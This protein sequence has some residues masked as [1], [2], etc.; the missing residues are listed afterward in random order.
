[1]TNIQIDAGTLMADLDDGIIS[2]QV[3]KY[4]EEGNTNLGKVKVRPGALRLPKDIKNFFTVDLGHDRMKPLGGATI[5]QDSAGGLFAA[6]D[7]SSTDEGKSLLARYKANDPAAP[8]RLSIEVDDVVITNGEITSGAIHGAAIVER[9]AFPSSSLFAQD[10]GPDDEDK[11]EVTDENGVVWVKKT[12]EIPAPATPAEGTT[13]TTAP[14]VT[15][16]KEEP[17]GAPVIPTTL[18]ASAANLVTPEGTVDEKSAREVFTLM[19]NAMKGDQEAMTLLAALTD[20]KVTGTGSLPVAGVLQPNWLGEIYQEKTYN[21]RYVPLITNGT[22]KA[23]DEKGFT[24]SAA[25]EPVQPWN[26]NKAA[27]P[28]SGGTTAVLSSIFQRWGWAADIAREFFDIPGN[29][30]VI[31]AFLRLVANSYDR[32]TDK[33]ALAQIVANATIIA[34]ETY[35]TTAPNPYSAVVGQLIQGIDAISSDPIDD[36]PSFAIAN[37]KAWREFIYT[38]KDALP[39]YL[40][41]NF[42]ITDQTG[43]AGRVRVVR[44][45]IGIDDTPAVL[46]GAKDAAHFNELPGKSPL[47]LSALDIANGGIDKAVVGYTQFMADYADALVIVGAADA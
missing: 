29:E 44:G 47:N 6:W 4:N 9:G 5:A 24:V 26:G 12:P 27:L 20:I 34:P 42:G 22:I 40:S 43:E 32:Q 17:V 3:L 46:V 10:V 2:G 13:T 39:E 36:T 16:T 1:M 28:S 7:I 21:R 11:D 14:V 33:W 38:P 37:A 30:S 15:T 23:I 25:T 41:L 45:D 31:A 35:P 18:A 8:R 19:A